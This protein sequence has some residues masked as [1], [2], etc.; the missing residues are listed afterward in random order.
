MRERSRKRERDTRE[1]ESA[2]VFY[3]PL[4]GNSR[5][6]LLNKA[7]SPVENGSHF[8]KDAGDVKNQR[9][10]EE[11]RLIDSNELSSFF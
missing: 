6:F 11:L 8:P 9:T 5:D 10:R 2:R 1:R 7:M 3:Y 4:Y